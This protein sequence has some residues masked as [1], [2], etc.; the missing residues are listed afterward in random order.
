MYIVH[1][2]GVSI[3]DK[4][5]NELRFLG[6]DVRVNDVYVNVEA[7][8][9]RTAL[10]RANGVLLERGHGPNPDGF[11]PGAVSGNVTEYELNGVAVEAARNY[12]QSVGI[13]VQVTDSGSALHE[14]GRLA[15][16]Y[17][18]FVSVHHNASQGHTAQ[19]C[20]ALYH[21]TMGDTE[22]R[23]LA[24]MVAGALSDALG[25]RNRG[26]K[27]SSLAILSGAEKTD[28]ASS[29]LAECY[30]LDNPSVKNHHELSRVAGQAIGK[31][32][33]EWLRERK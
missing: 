4:N 33:H 29:V 5:G 32:I 31:A 16:G 7:Q 19:G 23:Q 27:A 21:A 26:A 24:A 20:E 18:V 12:L 14:I 28:V 11:E 6:N 15:Q 30:F 1:K 8:R 9:P 13:P 17:D 25:F 2:Q 3:V 10:C 22:D